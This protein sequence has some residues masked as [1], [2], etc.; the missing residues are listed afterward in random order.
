V[1]NKAQFIDQLAERLD[2]DRR[3]A[4]AAL[5]AFVDSVYAAV[6]RGE[7]VAISGF[8]VFERRDRNARTARNPATGATVNVPATRVPAFRPGTEFREIASGARE[9]TAARTARAQTTLA[10]LA[11]VARDVQERATGAVRDAVDVV[12]EAPAKATKK[13]G[14][15]SSK[16]APATKK[17]AAKK[18]ASKSASKATKKAAAKKLAKQTPATKKAAAKKLASKSASKATKKAAAKKL[19]KKSP[20]KKGA[21]KKAAAKKGAAKKS[22]AKKTAKTAAKKAARRR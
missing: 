17:A 2:G 6:A 10:K 12:R 3:R 9:F 15:K 18:L 1:P 21:A 5:D 8:G 4:A 19:A 13:A 20:A 22:P 11:D 7:S 14:K 16:R